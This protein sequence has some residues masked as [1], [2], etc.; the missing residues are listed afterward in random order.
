[1][2]GTEGLTEEEKR[3]LELL[4][5]GTSSKEIAADLAISPEMVREH[6]QSILVKLQVHSRLEAATFALR[7][8]D[9]PPPPQA[10]SAALAVPFQRA[11]DIPRH[12][13][14]PLRRKPSRD[15]T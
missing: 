12:V 11:E 15:R 3:V 4:V 2:P 9:P 14:R 1:M 8:P 5:R 13:G 10:A 6:V 7:R